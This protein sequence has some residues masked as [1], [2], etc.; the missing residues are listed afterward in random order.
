MATLSEMI[1]GGTARANDLIDRPATLLRRGEADKQT[2]EKSKSDLKTA[3]TSRKLATRADARAEKADL[4]AGRAEGRAD[5][6]GVL[7]EREA[8]RADARLKLDQTKTGESVLTAQQN[9]ELA[10]NADKR[11][12]ESLGISQEELAM[13][14]QAQ[15]SGLATEAQNRILNTYADIRQ[16]LL[17][18]I[19]Q[20]ESKRTGE[21]D[22]RKLKI[23]ENADARDYD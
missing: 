4:R 15:V 16:E 17:L 3:K 8:G 12:T 5:K 22:D 21:G 10:V 19:R 2:R 6:A 1:L 9:R 11:A 13:A 23:L 20:E 18:D 7:A 14:K